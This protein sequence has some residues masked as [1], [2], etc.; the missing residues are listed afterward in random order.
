MFSSS[1]SDSFYVNKLF[2]EISESLN[3]PYG[4]YHTGIRRDENQVWIRSSDGAEVQLE[5]WYPSY[6]WSYASHEFLDFFLDRIKR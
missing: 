2:R 1:N 4:A 6:P 3:L 5:G